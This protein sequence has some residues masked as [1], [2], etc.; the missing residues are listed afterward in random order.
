MNARSLRSKAFL[1]AI[2][3]Q[4]CEIEPL[5]DNKAV[6]DMQANLERRILE[7]DIDIHEDEFQYWSRHGRQRKGK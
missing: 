3:G 2:S 1:R 6:A 7:M 4:T 5:V